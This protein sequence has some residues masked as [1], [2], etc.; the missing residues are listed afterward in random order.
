MKL[1]IPMAVLGFAVAAAQ[2][3]CARDER[4][5]NHLETAVRDPEGYARHLD[6]ECAGGRAASCTSVG[7]QTAFGT[8][9]R[10]KD[11]TAA[12]PFLEKACAGDDAQ[13]C[14][15]LAVMLDFG[16]GIPRDAARGAALHQKACAAGVQASCG[17]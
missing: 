9:G 17:R 7:V 4:D 6:E 15:E 11:P 3:G 16:R 14:H 10:K 12:I 8:Y 1:F 5:A 2:T 13:G